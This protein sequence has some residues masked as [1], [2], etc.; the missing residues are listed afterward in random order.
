MSI[1]DRASVGFCSRRRE[2]MAKNAL[3]AWGM[4]SFSVIRWRS[5]F[6]QCATI[7]KVAGSI[8]YGGH[9]GFCW[10]NPSG[11][12]MALGSTQP[13]TQI[14]TIDIAWGGWRGGGD[15]RC[16]GLTIL[17]PL[18][19]DCL[20]ILG[21]STFWNLRACPGLCRDSFNLSLRLLEDL[22]NSSLSLPP[23]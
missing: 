23:S 18:C 9:W 20:E 14:S 17:P 12:I 13:L 3:F 8:P 7:R 16:I 6:R 11:R 4:R 22:C 15:G 19:A 5:W 21:A 10:L 1:P 2:V